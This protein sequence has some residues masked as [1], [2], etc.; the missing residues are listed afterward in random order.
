MHEPNVENFLSSISGL[1]DKDMF[2]KIVNDTINEIKNEDL[3]ESDIVNDDSIISILPNIEIDLD[4]NDIYDLS[5]LKTFYYLQSGDDI[6]TAY[7]LLIEDLY[8]ENKALKLKQENT[9]TIINDLQELFPS[10]D[11][12]YEQIWNGETLESALTKIYDIV[13][14]G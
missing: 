3:D 4:D 10:D 12:V 7:E 14:D 2:N 5:N 6:V 1:I 11:D 8:R 13:F 9:D